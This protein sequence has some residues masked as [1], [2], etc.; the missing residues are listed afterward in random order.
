MPL[1]L[2][3]LA[4]VVTLGGAAAEHCCVDVSRGFE[5]GVTTQGNVQ[6]QMMHVSWDPSER[7]YFS[8]FSSRDPNGTA[9]AFRLWSKGD[10]HSH[11]TET[12][13]TEVGGQTA[14][15]TLPS[16]DPVTGP[17]QTCYAAADAVSHQRLSS[18]STVTYVTN[19][20][21]GEYT[22]V[23]TAGC[24]PVAV[25]TRDGDGGDAGTQS[26][27]IYYNQTLGGPFSQPAAPTGCTPIRSPSALSRASGGGGLG[28]AYA[29]LS[30]LVRHP[31]RL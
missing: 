18:L 17:N 24:I 5:L 23:D 6:Q 27:A 29:A 20:T 25:F 12:V 16:K 1:P 3:L 11:W 13:E 4:A 7:S 9:Q 8:T 31:F 22:T 19:R 21:A 30:A 2:T 28:G 10:E 14:C 15:Y 26:L